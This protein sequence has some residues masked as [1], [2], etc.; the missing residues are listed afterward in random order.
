MNFE[1]FEQTVLIACLIWT[2][3]ATAL[4]LFA[5]VI[6]RRQTGQAVHSVKSSVGLR[7]VVSV[8][9]FGVLVA[10]LALDGPPLALVVPTLVMA[11]FITFAAP[12]REDSVFGEHGVRRGW[13]ARRWEQLEGWRLSGNHLRFLVHGELVAVDIPEE[14]VTDLRARLQSICPES[15]SEFKV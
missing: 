7:V 5:I 1:S 9:L 14:H 12:R 13:H 11:L 2:A 6:G 10:V 15:E 3:L 8:L 4:S